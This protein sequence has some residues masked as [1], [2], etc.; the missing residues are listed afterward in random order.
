MERAGYF[1][2]SVGRAQGEGV[3][4]VPGPAERSNSTLPSTKILY[5]ATYPFSSVEGVPTPSSIIIVFSYKYLFVFKKNGISTKK[6]P[7]TALFN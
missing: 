2:R 1:N 3:I 5:I 6:M 4:P 7:P